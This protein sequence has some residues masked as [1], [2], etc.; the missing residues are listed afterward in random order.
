MHNGFKP[1]KSDSIPFVSER[2][3][4]AVEHDDGVIETAVTGPMFVVTRDDRAR[5]LNTTH[6]FKYSILSAICQVITR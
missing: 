2:Q 6:L 4:D 5:A 1:Y 3:D